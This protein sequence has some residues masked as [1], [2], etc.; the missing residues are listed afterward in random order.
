[1]GLS[2]TTVLLTGGSSGI[3]AATARTLAAAGARILVAGRNRARLQAVAEETGGIALVADLAAPEGPAALAEAAIRA[4]AIWDSDGYEA[5][6]G[7][8]PR[9]ARMPEPMSWPVPRADPP[10][11]GPPADGLA[12]ATVRRPARA[13]PPGPAGHPGPAGPAGPAGPLAVGARPA[14]SGID[15]LVNNAGIGWLAQMSAAKIAR[16]VAVNLTAP[17][18]LTRLL[19]PTLGAGGR[20]RVV[21]ISSIAGTTGVRQEAV[22]SGTKAGLGAFA[23]SLRYELAGTDVGVSVIFPGVVNTPF[24]ARRGIPYSRRRPIPISAQRVARVVLTAIEREQPVAFVPRWL[25]FP[26]WLHGAAPGTF[27]TLAARF[28]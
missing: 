24:F 10:G 4:A 25:G 11:S 8:V 16:M 21:F 18:E 15:I 28:G 1:M 20:G 13:R 3:G 14:A 22:Y 2:H 26:A 17:I 27:R 12:I 5:A 9:L 23:E 7:A 6:A 19:I